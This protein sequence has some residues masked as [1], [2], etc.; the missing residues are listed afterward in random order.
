MAYYIETK[1]CNEDSVLC[2]IYL[3]VLLPI[4]VFR[5]LAPYSLGANF[6]SNT[7][8]RLKIRLFLLQKYFENYFLYVIIMVLVALYFGGVFYGFLLKENKT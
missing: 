2:R 1:H 5:K 7:Y 6:I 3:P 4:P 8:K